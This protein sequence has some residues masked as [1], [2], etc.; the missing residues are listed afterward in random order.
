M[1]IREPA[2]AGMFYPADEQ[3]L[4]RDVEALL[5]TAAAT[6]FIP[7]DCTPKALIVPHA[8]YIYSGPAAAKAYHLLRPLREVI[9]R[10]LLLGPAH[11]VHL[12][13]MAIPAARHFRTPLGTVAL[14]AGALAETATLPGVVIA[15]AAHAEEHCLEVQLP[16]LQLLLADFTLVP[17]LVGQCDPERVAGVIDA[18]WGGEETLV[19]ISSD[20]S[21]FHSYEEAQRLDQ[22]TGQRILSKSSSLS[23]AEAC[24]ANAINGLMRAR[25]TEPLAIETVELCNSGDTAGDKSRVVGYG[26]FVVH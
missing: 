7:G 16:F 18:L 2:V 25:H 13:G 15:D 1:Q 8:G 11:R 23:G 6:P 26:S 12:Q 17:V 21:H 4:R 22:Q 19:L 24:G 20:L 5:D 10:V 14:D 3:Q 9:T